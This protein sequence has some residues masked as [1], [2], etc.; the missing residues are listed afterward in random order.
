MSKKVVQKSYARN[1]GSTFYRKTIRIQGEK[2][3]KSF[4]R[5]VDAERWYQEKKRE[6]ELVE[7]GLSI[8]KSDVSVA[9]FA[10]SWLEKRKLNGK[11][12]SSWESDETRLRKYILPHFGHR[13]MNKI[14]TKD[15]ES[16]LD[17]LVADDLVAP[18]TRNRIRSIANKMYN[19]GLRQEAVSNNPVRVI[20]KLKESMEAWDYWSSTEEILNYLTEAKSES[21]SF[22]IFASLSLNLGIRMGETL[23]LDHCDFNID[24]RRVHIAKIFEE[25]SGLV[26]QRT[27]GHKERWLGLNDSLTEAL[28]EY[29]N[30]TRFRHASDPVVCNEQGE[31]SYERQIRRIHERVCE[32]AKVKSIRIHDLRHTYASHYIMNGGSLAE[33]QSLLG[34]SNP[35]MTL[36]YAHMAPGY[37]EKKAGVV[38]FALPQQNVVPL[39][40]T[41]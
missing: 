16:F 35:M 6:K 23:A 13:E 28:I 21:P 38:S 1:D 37:L 30:S 29:R 8:G 25:T 39:R 12:M 3:E 17:G 9:D 5:K 7:N 26:F 33:L 10:S 27:K 24:Q 14:S 40:K 34:H 18:A 32:R 41:R 31:R 11:P 22:F 2:I 19:D 36:K 20:P 4:S 15:W